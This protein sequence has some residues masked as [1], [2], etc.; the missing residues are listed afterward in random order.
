MFHQRLARL[1]QQQTYDVTDETLHLP[2]TYSR[3]ALDLARAA[4]FLFDRADQRNRLFN[5]AF[6]QSL[7]T[8]QR[9]TREEEAIHQR[10]AAVFKKLKEDLSKMTLADVAANFY[11]L[12]LRCIRNGIL[13]GLGRKATHLVGQLAKLYVEFAT[14]ANTEKTVAAMHNATA[15]SEMSLENIAVASKL[16]VDHGT[17]NADKILTIISQNPGLVEAEGGLAGAAGEVARIESAKKFEQVFAKVNTYE[18]ARNKALEII[19]DLGPESKPYTGRLGVGQGKIV[20]RQSA[21]G[22]VRWRL[23]YDPVK[24][25]HINIEDFRAGKK[26]AATKIAIPFEGD[27]KT[28]ET[29]LKHLNR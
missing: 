5:A 16:A 28:I 23:D 14:A 11:G 1:I 4:F 2:Q 13:F 19:G 12:V 25:P 20:G 17:Q 7:E 22:K 8:V 26:T 18:Q 29:L 6:I 24:G 9:I 21:N 3:T 10:V 15:A 27:L